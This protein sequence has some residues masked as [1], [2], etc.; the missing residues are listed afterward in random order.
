MIKELFIQSYNFLRQ[1]VGVGAVTVLFA[2]AVLV[3]F[4]VGKSG[5]G[6]LAPILLSVPVAIGHAAG[7]LFDAIFKKEQKPGIRLITVLFAAAIVLLAVSSSG[8]SMFSRQYA[9]RAE[10][11]MHIPEGM[12]EAMDEVLADGKNAG[13]LTMPGWEVFF[14][15]YSS[16]FEVAD[17]EV[18]PASYAELSGVH[19]DMRIVSD[20]ARRAGCE[21]V[22]LSKGLW[23]EL[24]ISRFGYDLIYENDSCE[25]YR[26]VKS[27]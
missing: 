7:C 23:P 15:N 6:R 16:R 17:R 13:V 2:A 8:R 4:T 1:F 5:R 10:N 26:E 12:S 24:P 20:E 22:V 25:V 21:Y 9:T 14:N 11:V 3:L 27:P 19:P 18:S